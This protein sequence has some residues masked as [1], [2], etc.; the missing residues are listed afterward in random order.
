MRPV[1]LAL[2]TFAL[3]VA[4]GSSSAPGR[5]PSGGYVSCT[6]DT[7]CVVTTRTGCCAC[8]PGEPRALPKGKLEKQEARCAA[9]SCAPCSDRLDCPSSAPA[10]AFVA[11]CKDGTCAA[12]PR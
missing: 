4:C 11:A 6:A 7:D 10:T 3:V 1:A 9:T 2:V 5:T 12:V 8:C